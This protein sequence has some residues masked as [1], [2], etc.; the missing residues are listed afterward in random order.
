MAVGAGLTPADAEL[1]SFAMQTGLLW[2]GT[3]NVTVAKPFD[4][5]VVPAN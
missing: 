4:R 1:V 3:G 2:K 5:V